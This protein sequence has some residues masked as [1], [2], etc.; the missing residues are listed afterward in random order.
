[1]GLGKTVEAMCVPSQG[2]T[3]VVCPTSVLPNWHAELARFRPSLRVN[4]YHGPARQLDDS[5]PTSR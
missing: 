3:L 1:M 5:A 4:V 2:P